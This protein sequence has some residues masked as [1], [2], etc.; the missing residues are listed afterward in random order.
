MTWKKGAQIVPL[1]LIIILGFLWTT[2]ALAA[3]VDVGLGARPVGLGRAFVGLADDV[4][5]ML[6][7]PA[8]L[9]GLEKMELTSTYARLYPGIEDD[10]LHMGFAGVVRPF[11][12]IGTVGF[13]ITNLWADLYGENVFYFSLGRKLGDN[14]SLGGNLKMLRWS[15]EGYSDPETGLSESG[16]SW[17]G[18]AL[19]AGI[20][21]RLK[22]ERLLNMTGADGLQLGLAVFNV[23]QPSVAENGSGDAKLPLGLE[24]GIVYFK[25][26]GKSL[27][28]LSRRDEKTRLHIGQEIE[29]WNQQT[30]VGPSS[31][32]IRAGA[33]TMLSGQKG[34]ELDF[35]CGFTLREILLDYVYVLPM[36]LKEAGG[37]HKVSMGYSF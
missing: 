30:R 6:Y 27:L 37:C 28:S 3:F 21:Y 20:L 2:D 12:G 14:L 7:N 36:A 9:A 25:N 23:N 18:F 17:S 34:G 26:T 33:F 32:L 11:R 29:L 1:L 10:K 22:N 16:L 5:A 8:G 24:G 15:A 31:F 35:G 19:D 4:N 13:G